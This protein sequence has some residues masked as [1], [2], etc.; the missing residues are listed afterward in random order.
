MTIHST[1]L[2]DRGAEIDEGVEIGPYA[3]IGEG[4]RISRGTRVRHHASIMGPAI[5][6]R[7]NDIFPFASLGTAPQ[8]LG[9]RGEPTRLETGDGNVFREF[10]TVNRGTAKGGGLTRIASTSS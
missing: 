1:A 5:I 10:V 8:D 2:I 9:Y 3:I 4:V 7:E 6:G